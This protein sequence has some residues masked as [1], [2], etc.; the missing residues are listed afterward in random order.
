M[1]WKE[2]TT[3]TMVEVEDRGEK[4]RSRP[5]KVLQPLLFHRNKA[6]Y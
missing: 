4:V 5:R 2:I 1:H 3:M 6:M